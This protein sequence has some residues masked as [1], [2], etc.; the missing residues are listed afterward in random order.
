MQLA[1]VDQ[2]DR[3]L[4]PAYALY[5]LVIFFLQRCEEPVLPVLNDFVSEPA[6]DNSSQSDM[7]ENVCSNENV[8]SKCLYIVYIILCM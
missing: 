8:L 3:G 2:Q 4:W 7:N 5:L 1:Q 6:C